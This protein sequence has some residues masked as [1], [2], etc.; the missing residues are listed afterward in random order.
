MTSRLQA[1]LN[2]AKGTGGGAAL[3]GVT[4]GVSNY[5]AGGDLD[6]AISGAV[7]GALLGGAGGALMRNSNRLAQVAVAG[8]VPALLAQ[9]KDRPMV[10]EYYAPKHTDALSRLYSEERS[11]KENTPEWEEYYRA[12]PD[13]YE[14]RYG[15]QAAVASEKVSA[16]QS[17]VSGPGS[18]IDLDYYRLHKELR[19][20]GYSRQEREKLLRNDFATQLKDMARGA[21]YGLTGGALGGLAGYGLGKGLGVEDTRLLANIAAIGGAGGLTLGGLLATKDIYDLD[22]QAIEDAENLGIKQANAKL[23]ALQGL[24]LLGVG[25]GVGAGGALLLGDSE[26]DYQEDFVNRLDEEDEYQRKADMG[27]ISDAEYTAYL[28][29]KKRAGELAMPEHRYAVTT[30]LDNLK[31]EASMTLDDISTME[32]MSGTT[33]GRVFTKVGTII[34][35]GG[36]YT[37]YDQSGKNI[38]GEF[39]KLSEAQEYAEKIAE[40][41]YDQNSGQVLQKRLFGRDR[42]LASATGGNTPTFRAENMSSR[43]PMFTSWANYAR[44]QEAYRNQVNQ[45]HQAYQGSAGAAT[46]Y[47]GALGKEIEQ[48]AAKAKTPPA[49]LA[50]PPASTPTPQTSAPQSPTPAPQAQTPKTTAP[51]APSKLLKGLKWGGGLAALGGLGYLGYEYFRPKTYQERLTNTLSTAGRSVASYAKKYGPLASMVGQAYGVDPNLMGFM[52]NASQGNFQDIPQVLNR[53][54][55]SQGSPGQG[56]T[57]SQYYR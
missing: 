14:A 37:L 36:K 5:L 51:K 46:K 18:A 9:V 33:V 21:G 1:A 17:D 28:I 35:A 48:A 26:E 7:S 3:G 34:D 45:L 8:G 56:A 42:V 50:S 10:S 40:T 57:T 2:L 30:T 47:E 20:K 15:K 49:S 4:G 43:K 41:Y 44:Q 12:N 52:A 13:R 38:Y 22:Q 54:A 11:F 53:Y 16:F 6:H 19:E 27:I 29:G 31:K 32:S 55:N 23:T 25:L 24:G 39:T